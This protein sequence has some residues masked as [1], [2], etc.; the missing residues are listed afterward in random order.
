[1]R[2]IALGNI[3]KESIVVSSVAKVLNNARTLFAIALNIS[4]V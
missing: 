2:R 4:V 3:G 1:M